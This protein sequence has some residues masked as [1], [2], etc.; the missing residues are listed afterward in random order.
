[1][2]TTAKFPADFSFGYATASAQ[3]EGAVSPF[4]LA[5][6]F[7]DRSSSHLVPSFLSLPR[8]SLPLV[9]LPSSALIPLEVS[10]HALTTPLSS[11]QKPVD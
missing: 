6:S 5:R 3:V 9:P 1:M 2:S 11:R 4:D 8:P 10:L 7:I